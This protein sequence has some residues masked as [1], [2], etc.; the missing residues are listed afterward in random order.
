MID[1]IRSRRLARQS[2]WLPL[3]AAMMAVFAASG[4]ENRDAGTQDFERAAVPSSTVK[5]LVKDILQDQKR[6]WT[7]PLHTSRKSAQWLLIFGGITGVAVATDR[8]TSQ[9]LPN[10]PDQLA[11][12]RRVSQAGAAYTLVPLV[13]GI[14]AIGALTKSTKLRGT[15]LLGA[16]AIADALVVSEALKLATGR[17]RPLEGDGTGRFF[18]GSNSF[19]SGHALESFALAS[20]IAHR[21]R[22]R[23]AIVIL[24][25]GVAGLVTASRFSTRRHFASDLVVGSAMGWVLGRHVYVSHRNRM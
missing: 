1:S 7:S 16:E 18:H 11:F 22:N 23:K 20:L 6:I 3:A 19:P 5:G 25:Y 10:T 14:Y 17:Q 2:R 24:A 21:Y 13:G 12:S 9:A 8:R 15:G 4:Q